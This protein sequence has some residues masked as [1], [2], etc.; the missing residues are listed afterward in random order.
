LGYIVLA[1][2]FSFETGGRNA[3]IDELYVAPEHRG[4]GITR[5]A[6]EFIE[7]AAQGV[8]ALHLEVSRDNYKALGLCDRAG[9]VNH[10]RY[11]MTKQLN[12]SALG[13]SD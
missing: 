8:K 3:F 11:L 5:R 4:K 10:D 7:R 12:R 9:Y 6:L 13:D 1:F 2:G